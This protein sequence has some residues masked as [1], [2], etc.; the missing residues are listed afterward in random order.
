MKQKRSYR[1]TSKRPMEEASVWE[2]WWP[3]DNQN[4]L[5]RWSLPWNYITREGIIKRFGYMPKFESYMIHVTMPKEDARYP[6]L[7]RE[8]IKYNILSLVSEKEAEALTRVFKSVNGRELGWASL[9]AMCQR[10][11]TH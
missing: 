8:K 11:A 1:K 9:A 4:K 7:L 5:R 6:F 3:H 10:E 2:R